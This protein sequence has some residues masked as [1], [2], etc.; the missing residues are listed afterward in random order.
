VF[1]LDGSLQR[2]FRMGERR[3]VDFQMQATN[4]LNHVTITS[5]GTVLGSSNW[6]LA[7]NAAAMRKVSFNLRFR[8]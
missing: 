6:G 1:S 7:S 2:I 4:L 8:F 3:S 5:W